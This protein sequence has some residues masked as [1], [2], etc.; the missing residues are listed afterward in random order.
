MNT[1][2]IITG[3]IIVLI[4]TYTGFKELQET[5]PEPIQE[6][7]NNKPTEPPE[8][9]REKLEKIAGSCLHRSGCKF[10]IWTYC[11][12]KSNIELM[13]IIKDFNLNR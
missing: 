4:F 9:D 1:I 8:I 5:D 12:Y 2:L 13:D 11:R 7:Y 6:N 3:F 10:D